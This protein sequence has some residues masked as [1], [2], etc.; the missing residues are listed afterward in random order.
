[1]LM[2]TCLYADDIEVY[3]TQAS[4]EKIKPNLLFVLDESKS[5]GDNLDGDSTTRTEDLKIAM[6]AIF[7]TPENGGISDVN[8]AMLGYSKQTTAGRRV[9]SDFQDV[10]TNRASFLSLIDSIDSF[11][12]TVTVQAMLASVDWFKGSFTDKNGVTVTTPITEELYCAQNHIILLTDGAPFSDQP[13][14]PHPLKA[15]GF[16][17]EGEACTTSDLSGFNDPSGF[18]MDRAGCTG[19]IAKSAFVND[20]F[21]SIQ[22]KQHVITQTIGF[23]TGSAEE[24]YLRDIAK[25]GGG[26]YYESNDVASLVIAIK[27]IVDD[28]KTVPDTYNYNAPLVPF[29]SDVSAVSGD[30][31]YIPVFEPDVGAFWKGN[32]KRYTINISDS[33]VTLESDGGGAVIDDNNLFLNEA[34]SFWSGFVD[35]EKILEGGAASKLS[36]TRKL[37]TYI[38]GS[39]ST[40][41]A[42]NVE[43]HVILTNALITHALLGLPDPVDIN[44]FTA[45]ENEARDNLI[46]WVNWNGVDPKNEHKQEMGAPLHT[47]PVVVSYAGA[48]DMILLSTTEGVLEAIDTETGEELW[49][50]MPEELIE[51]IRDLELNEKTSEPIYG[52]DGPLTVYQVN[53]KTMV[54]FGMR[55]GGRNYYALDVTNREAPLFAWKIIGGT[56]PNFEALGQ[57]WSKPQF[58][59]ILNPLGASVLPAN[60]EVLA[61]GGGYDAAKQDVATS[62]VDDDFGSSIYIVDAATGVFIHSITNDNMK[63]GIPSDILPIDINTNGVTD[64]IY[65]ADVAGKIIRVDLAE[66]GSGISVGV[67]ADVNDGGSSFHRFFNTP[68]VAYFDRGGDRFLAILIGSGQRSNPLGKEVLDSFYMIKDP[69]IWVKGDYEV[70]ARRDLYDATENKI[71]SS[72]EELRKIEKTALV[73]RQGWFIDLPEA[74]EKVFSKASVYDYAVMFTSY[75]GTADDIED[76]CSAADTKSKSTFWAVDMI[77]GGAIFPELDG[78]DKHL[79]TSDRQKLLTIPG[80]PPAPT[81]LFPATDDGKVGKQVVALVGLQEMVRLSDRFRAMSWESVVGD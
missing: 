47:Q 50:F 31:I 29:N 8:A 64:R 30:S 16:K 23:F 17:Y 56:S 67:I 10:E 18:S 12:G 52:L 9:I 32:L 81:L 33:G 22:K 58:I 48:N 59:K 43:N 60:I 3:R 55:R 51:N 71:Q 26:K 54:V 44:N 19:D 7:A 25:R 74:G 42:T 1:L 11:K 68:E 73:G 80:I 27:E 14:D 46:K 4:D 41:L 79:K 20:L 62:Q 65:A 61:F 78:D 63:N 53:G 36:G 2:S 6:K 76:I 21:L 49:A 24:K 57:T 77:T 66:D 34:K 45:E 70:V 5:M 75:S 15:S 40:E 13:G 38:D 28:A 39:S 37:Y 72:D 69:N 35:G